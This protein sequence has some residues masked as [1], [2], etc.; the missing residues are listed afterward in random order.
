MNILVFGDSIGAGAF[1]TRHNGWVSLMAMDQYKKSLAS[2]GKEYNDVINISISGNT[3][4]DL[5]LRVEGD[6]K[7]RKGQDGAGVSILAIGTNDAALIG[8]ENQVTFEIFA[9]NIKKLAGVLKKSSE[10]FVVL[11]LPPVYEML[12]DPWCFDITA[13][14]KNE[15]LK[16]Y[17]A[18]LQRIAKEKEL[19]FIPMQD[20]LDRNSDQHLPDGLHPNAEGH[21][22]IFERVKGELEKAGIL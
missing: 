9:E 11:G 1:D 7:S 5:W 18:E 21:Q 16:K 20:V 19:L 17:D 10:Q 8:G 2:R 14:W 4:I 22:L 13:I 6:I 3:S 12:S 15:E